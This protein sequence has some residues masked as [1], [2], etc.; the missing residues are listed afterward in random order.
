MADMTS[1]LQRIDAEFNAVDDKV[2]KNQQANLEEYRR[3]DW[4]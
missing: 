4:D 3:A 2:K 1:L